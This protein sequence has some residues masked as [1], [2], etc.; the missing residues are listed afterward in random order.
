MSHVTHVIFYKRFIFLCLSVTCG[1]PQCDY[2][3]KLDE[4]DGRQTKMNTDGI[5]AKYR[6]LIFF[7][8]FKDYSMEMLNKTFHFGLELLYVFKRH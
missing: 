8:Q 2:N 3:D 1:F 6:F 7:F 4:L 5:K